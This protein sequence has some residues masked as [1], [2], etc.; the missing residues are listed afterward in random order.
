MSRGVSNLI[1][2]WKSRSTRAADKR[3]RAR[4]EG[5]EQRVLFSA[6]LPWTSLETPDDDPNPAPFEQTIESQSNQTVDDAGVSEEIRPSIAVV[7]PSYLAEEQ[8]SEDQFTSQLDLE[9]DLRFLNA[10]DSGV[11]QLNN[12]LENA[13]TLGTLDVLTTAEPEGIVLGSDTLQTNDLLNNASEMMALGSQ[14][15]AT[16]QINIQAQGLEQFEDAD[17]FAAVFNQLVTG[18]VVVTGDIVLAAQGNTGSPAQTVTSTT[19]GLSINEDGGNDTYLQIDD[20]KALLTLR[21]SLTFETRF[22]T[23]NPSAQAFVSYHTEEGGDEFGIITQS[24]GDLRIE[25]ADDFVETSG[26]DFSALADGQEHTLSVT[27]D[28]TNGDWEVY[29]DGAL[30]DSGSGL[31]TGDAIGSISGLGVLVLGNE[32]DAPGSIFNPNVAN[33]ATLFDTRLFDDVR[34]ATEIAENF[35]STVVYDTEGLL[36]NW[37][38]DDVSSNGII[39]ETVA[40]NNLTVMHTSEAGFVDSVPETSISV[41][42]NSATGTPVATVNGVDAEREALIQSLLAAD[43]NL[44]YSAETDKF[45]LFNDDMLDFN[46]SR[47]AAEN[48]TLNGVS[49]QLATIRSAHENN[50]IQ[51]AFAGNGQIWLGGTDATVEGQWRWIED[52]QESDQFW[53]GGSNGDN[54]GAYSN[55]FPGTQPSGGADEDGIRIDTSPSGGRWVDTPTNILSESLIEFNADEVLDATLALNYTIAA[56]TEAGAFAIDPDTCLLYTSP[57]PRDATLSRMPSSA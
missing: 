15:D 48:A 40:G 11:S 5:L 51:D 6:D 32:Q 38:F 21:D 8:L 33:Q 30:V 35:D 47:T 41:D 23:T 42:E 46:D 27:W 36:A 17:E 24:D 3:K 28:N 34:T 14:L 19:G 1:K 9:G 57:S 7:D 56:Q 20:G 12:L 39:L 16:S 55:W 52:G 45:Y 37:I 26:Y 29:V 31:A 22:T 2:W 49:G 50:F 43:P 53:D 13:P 10:D 18:S 25:I 4:S 54:N 44:A